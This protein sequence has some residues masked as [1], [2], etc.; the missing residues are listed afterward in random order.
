MSPLREDGGAGTLDR[1]MTIVAVRCHYS[2]YRLM[3]HFVK[4]IEREM[5]GSIKVNVPISVKML[6]VRCHDPFLK[7]MQGNCVYDWKMRYRKSCH[8]AVLLW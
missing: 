8:S 5:R 4:K 6:C 7:K 2:V 3:I 1:E